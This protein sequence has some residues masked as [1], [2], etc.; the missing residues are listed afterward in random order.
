MDFEKPRIVLSKCIEF[1]PCRYNG[2]MIK[3][4]IVKEL[5]DYADFLPVCPEVGMG[6]GVPRDPI[7]VVDSGGRLELFQP[8]T[9][10][11]FTDE[12]NEFSQTF[13][14]SISNVDGFILKNKSPSCGVKAIN[15]YSSFEDSRPKKDG[16]GLF[17][18]HVS[19][20]FPELPI[21]DEGRL[22]N[23]IIRENFLTNIFALA[24]FRRA[25][26]GDLNDLIAFHTKNKLL[27]MS[28]SPYYLKLMG[29]TLA[30][31]DKKSIDNIKTEY[32]GFLFR[33]LAE[34]S[35]PAL[36]VS[37]M[38]HALGYFSKEIK[39]DEKTL[40]LNTLNDYKDGRIPLLVCLKMLELWIIRL[41]N[42]YLAGQTFLNHI[43]MI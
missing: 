34:D 2:L 5:K 3:S 7:R 31:N 17:A 13:L 12:M 25:I 23:L 27:L 21:E 6:L 42:D 33:S 16:I 9:G 20:Y 38:K 8:K 40:F 32:Q 30:N 39:H 1:A 29:Q 36:N 41:E 26:S 4:S 43:L 35:N 22:R 15:I 11:I 24:K 19:N 14:E 18:A 28:R 37:V 10:K